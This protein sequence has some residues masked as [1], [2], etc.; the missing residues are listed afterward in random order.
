MKKVNILYVFVVIYIIKCQ[1]K[2][3]EQ[4]DLN[5]TD[6]G[7]DNGI[8]FS[9]PIELL[10]E[11]FIA[12]R[13]IERKQ[14]ILRIPY[15]ITYNINKSLDLLN[16]NELKSQYEKFVKL[17]VPT[18]EPHHINLQKE[19]IF[20][21]YILYLIQHEPELYQ[22]T[23]FYEKY[24]PY[25]SS[26]KK[27]LPKS[28]LFYTNDQIEYLQGTYLGKFHNRIKKLFQDEINILKNESF[29][30]KTIDF[31]DFV[32]YRLSTINK[33]LEVLGHISMIPF[34]NNFNR[35]YMYYN[36]LFNIDKE[37]NIKIIS[38]RKI[39]K[40]ESI[41]L[42]SPK[43]ANVERMIFEGELNSYLVNYKENYLIP[44]FSPGL[45][46]KYN[47]T[48]IK[49]F[50]GYFINF[51]ELKYEE[52]AINLYKEY[53]ELFKGDKEDEWAYG[54]L[55]ENVDYYREYVEHFIKDRLNK[56]FTDDFDKKIIERAL[57]GE[58]NVLKRA[59]ELVRNKLQQ[60]RKIKND[61]ENKN[62]KNDEL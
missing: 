35:D 41:I 62:N 44:A 13:D 61:K 32:Q 7:L 3:K 58:E 59:K 57:K 50:N 22:K 60:L 53:K 34:L 30:N 18:Y 4:Q 8:E 42:I 25:I 47:I 56:E 6:W 36:A 19:E 52:K 23:K 16:S 37:G 10:P 40:G 51:A 55:L 29:Y 12:G 54:V 49:L 46:Y 5:Y 31:K 2:E 11:K 15:D 28:P 39:R 26:L 33:G 17:D 48:N 24:K 20:L 38:K 43:R 14:E 1:Q 27:Y 21:S 9:V 45:F